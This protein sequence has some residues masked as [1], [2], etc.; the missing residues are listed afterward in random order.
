MA[1]WRKPWSPIWLEQ[2]EHERLRQPG[3]NKGTEGSYP[4]LYGCD[5]LVTALEGFYSGE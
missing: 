4:L 2:N 5:F 1:C 3:W